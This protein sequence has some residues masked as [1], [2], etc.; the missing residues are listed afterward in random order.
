M[1][2]SAH[3]PHSSAASVLDPA[4]NCIIYL[5][6]EVKIQSTLMRAVGAIK[7]LPALLELARAHAQLP[8]GVDRADFD[9]KLKTLI[10]ETP[11]IF[12]AEIE[13]S[14]YA[15]LHAHSLVGMWSAVEVCMEDTLTNAM[16]HDAGARA[17]VAT[18]HSKVVLGAVASTSDVKRAVRKW[19][20]LEP[21]KSIAGRW[22]SMLGV[23]G[24][25]L[26]R[27]PVME[28]DV[29]EANAVRNCLLHRHGIVDTQAIDAAPSLA[30][31]LNK[32]LAISK[33]DYLRYYDA[34]GKFITRL[35]DG[36]TKSRYVAKPGMGSTAT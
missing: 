3:A 19:E 34:L 25:I 20:R 26:Q 16:L 4:T 18:A 27:D 33:I 8:P 23:L 24:V 28:A 11:T 17:A 5:V 7:G 13:Q 32:K 21:T 2:S 1:T 22:I 12:A 35:I 36:I 14:D 29:D 9:S 6:E 30:P 31:L 10:A 15:V